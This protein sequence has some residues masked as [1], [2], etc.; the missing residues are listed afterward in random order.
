MS[1]NLD[2]EDEKRIIELAKKYGI[3][4][5]IL[6]GSRARGDNRPDSDIDLALLGGMGLKVRFND[7]DYYNEKYHIIF[8]DDE[9]KMGF[10]D[11]IN[12]DGIVIYE[13]KIDYGRRYQ[14]FS[15]ALNSFEQAMEQRA[16][17]LDGG[18]EAF[19]NCFKQSWKLLKVFLE[20]QGESF[21][22]A[23]S[24]SVVI[25]VASRRGI[26]RDSL[27]WKKILDTYD[28]GNNVEDKL[29]DMKTECLRV[30]HDLKSRMDSNER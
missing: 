15:E 20:S 2:K 27:V 29:V 19:Q 5:V 8:L 16:Y 30:F 4:K 9:L 25:E 18:V 6:F 22:K 17:S 23:V 26:I 12:K 7:E 11:S 1:Y 13:D 10:R 21:D 24:P 3:E 28:E 14:L